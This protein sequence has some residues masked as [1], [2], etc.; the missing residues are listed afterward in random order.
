MNSFLKGRDLFANNIVKNLKNQEVVNILI[1]KTWKF[2]VNWDILKS[3]KKIETRHA[4][5]RSIFKR[6]LLAYSLLK[7]CSYMGILGLDNFHDLWRLMFSIFEHTYS[8]TPPLVETAD[9][10]ERLNS[11]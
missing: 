7:I 3:R 4:C 11:F 6:A 8:I 1:Q 10:E 9:F 5:N 2:N